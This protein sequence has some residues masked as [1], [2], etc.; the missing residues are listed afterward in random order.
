MTEAMNEQE[1]PL[2]NS[3]FTEQTLKLAVLI[4]AD[5]DPD[6]ARVLANFGPPP[7]WQRPAGFATLI[8]II[9][10]QQVSLASAKAA[11][12]RLEEAIAPITPQKFLTLD[13]ARL[14]AIGFS[15]QKTL[16]GRTLAQAVLDGQ[17]DLDSLEG[18]SDD[19]VRAQ[20]IQLKGI[21]R[22]T[23]DIYLMEALLRVDI[24][25]TSDLALAIA[26]QRVKGL[27]RV[28]IPAALE[29]LGELYRPWRAAAARLFWHDYLSRPGRK[30]A[31]VP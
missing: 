22:W 24:W 29:T 26:V 16:Y 5:R 30:T 1:L 15:R 11:Y 3:P 8:Y 25:P 10:E 31:V 2:S 6:L 28:P 13:D 17:I 23:A 4:L 12:R 9:L 18:F 21:G 27:E 19:E 20:L 14:K 7:L